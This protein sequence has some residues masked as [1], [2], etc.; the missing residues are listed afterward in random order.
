MALNGLL[1][2]KIAKYL[3]WRMK[4]NSKKKPTKFRGL[5]TKLLKEYPGNMLVNIKS[6][7]ASTDRS[8]KLV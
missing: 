3:R 2:I 6:N 7:R 8:T 4:L 1:Q 5:T